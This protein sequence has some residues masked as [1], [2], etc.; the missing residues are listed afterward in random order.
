MQRRRKRRKERKRRSERTVF[1]T[2]ERCDIVEKAHLDVPTVDDVQSLVRV[3]LE[4][5]VIAFEGGRGCQ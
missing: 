5:D 4:L 3:N 2:C 1:E